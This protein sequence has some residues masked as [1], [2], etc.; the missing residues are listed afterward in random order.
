MSGFLRWVGGKASISQRVIDTFPREFGN[1]WEPFM[2]GASIFFE[3]KS[4]GK[5]TQ[6]ATLTDANADLVTAFEVVRDDPQSVCDR[7]QA[8]AEQVT[9]RESFWAFRSN[10][11]DACSNNPD[12]RADLA[13][14][15]IAI[16]YLSMNKWRVNRA[17]QC[18]AS[19]AVARP[20]PKP[21]VIHEASRA[22]QWTT[23]LHEDFSIADLAVPGDL[24]YFDP[25]YCGVNLRYTA[26]GFGRAE[27]ERLAGT[28]RQLEARGVHVRISNSMCEKTLEIYSG[29]EY[30]VIQVERR[31]RGTRKVVMEVIL[32]GAVSEDRAAQG[33]L[34]LGSLFQ[35]SSPGS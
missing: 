26:A 19:Y 20:M 34:A 10:K 23:I 28:A 1:Y 21:R 31:I 8:I 30:R 12:V 17:G 35:E 29:F 11:P 18:T 5:I 9:D 13:A 32:G 3:L 33:T 27:H 2:G 22:L 14:W 6:G 4:R 15:L 16:N 25:P 24:V 7:L